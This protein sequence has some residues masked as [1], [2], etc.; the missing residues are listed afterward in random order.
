MRQT[1]AILDPL[2]R[3][4]K[5]EL[6]KKRKFLSVR[7][8]NGPSERWGFKAFKHLSHLSVKPL[9]TLRVCQVV[10]CDQI[11]MDLDVYMRFSAFMDEIIVRDRHSDTESLP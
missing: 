10:F 2:T 3:S 11:T 6:R 5:D 4:T 9:E 8:E 7:E 1:N